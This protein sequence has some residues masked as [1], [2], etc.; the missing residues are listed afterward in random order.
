MKEYTR[1]PLKLP[2]LRSRQSNFATV[3][4]NAR[5]DTKL[6]EQTLRK[7]RRVKVVK[8]TERS[9]SSFDSSCSQCQAA[10]ED[11]VYA[12]HKQGR[13]HR[14]K[15]PLPTLSKNKPSSNLS[16]TSDE[17]VIRQ[18]AHQWEE[19]ARKKE[20][21][22]KKSRRAEKIEETLQIN[23]QLVSALKAKLSIIDS[24]EF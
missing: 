5:E 2:E 22:I 14:S 4:E 7:A 16:P 13:K 24:F 8:D 15:K 3:V 20:Q 11:K 19:S 1:V 17:W 18:K 10:K 23:G 9:Y 12:S 21:L 6:I